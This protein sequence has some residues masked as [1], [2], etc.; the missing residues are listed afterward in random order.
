MKNGRFY[1][2]LAQPKDHR[3]KRLWTLERIAEHICSGRAHVNEVI[4]NKPGRA[5]ALGK[6]TRRRLVKFFKENFQSSW[7][8]ILASLGWNEAGGRIPCRT[9]ADEHSL[10]EFE[11]LH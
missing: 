11:S 1:W 6:R 10:N 9:F 4:N 3:G 5:G 7:P 8:D 2:L